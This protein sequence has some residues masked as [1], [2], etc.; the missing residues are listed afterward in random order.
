MVYYDHQNKSA[1]SAET[2]KDSER[3]YDMGYYEA[4]WEE[5]KGFLIK[6]SIIGGIISL[7][8]DIL[9]VAGGS[10]SGY[11]ILQTVV[12][13]LLAL[14]LLA[15]FFV[16]TVAIVMMMGGSAQ[17]F[18]I[19][20]LSGL[21]TAMISSIFD[22]GPGMILGIIELMLFGTLFAIVAAGYCIYLPVSTIYYFVR[23]KMER[24]AV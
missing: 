18:A 14:L 8:T 13:F 4:A 12:S 1:L 7:I 2:K 11:N 9:M 17:G 5:R 20:I 24:A 22:F 16:P 10:F 6:A 19:G 21:W 3:R 23:S 15:I